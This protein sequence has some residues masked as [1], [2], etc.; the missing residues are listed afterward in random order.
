MEAGAELDSPGHSSDIVA[1]SCA[2]LRADLAELVERA[3]GL[4]ERLRCHARRLAATRG[5]PA[6]AAAAA[7]PPARL[8]AAE[9]DAIASRAAAAAARAGRDGAALRRLKRAR[10]EAAAR[11]RSVLGLAAAALAAVDWQAPSF[12]HAL[13]SHAG[14]LAGRITGTKND[15]QRDH[16][17]AADA[18][19]AAWL[20]AFVDAPPH[21]ALQAY[22]TAS[23]MAAFALA[24]S[25]VRGAA[26]E[27]PVLLGRSCWFQSR[28]LVRRLW[29]ER[30]V[31]DVDERDAEA[32]AAQARQA[33]A[34]AVF[35]DS[36]GNTG[37]L[38]LADLEGLLP[39]LAAQARRPLFV[40][41]DNTLLATA[42]QP[43][44]WLPP[45]PSRLR[46]LV[47]E[48]LNKYH[49]A[50]ADRCGAG[51]LWAAGTGL[52]GLF[53]TRMVLGANIP[54]T[55]V[56][57]LPPPRRAALDA[58]LARIGRNALHVAARV[59]AAID[60]GAGALPFAGVVHAALEPHPDALR[61]RAL[62]FAGGSFNLLPRDDY[63]GT[64]AALRFIDLAVHEARRAGVELVA[65]AGFGFDATRL[66]LTALFSAGQ[67][68]PFLRVAA[69]CECLADADRLA[70][71]LVR[72]MH[73]LAACAPASLLDDRA[74]ALR[75]QHESLRRHP[76]G[77]WRAVPA[78]PDSPSAA[79]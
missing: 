53:E 25:F 4:R 6:P 51:L 1:T 63:R 20:A 60:E 8:L 18:Y 33:G 49:Q 5:L 32:V 57:A 68:R 73:A 47:V 48:S 2:E 16:H 54:D 75:L 58:R 24:A 37:E 69:G 28:L 9:C 72:A 30:K 23:G 45:P 40:V 27:A 50:G 35:L 67:A 46:L 21:A 43:A 78:W 15:Y 36:L 41:V 59:Q 17:G 7:G 13:H 39:R 65:G 52:Q 76:S 19:E 3:R 38:P 71:V 56:H 61:A 62:A 29:P 55:H 44:R 70:A 12:A 42:C 22:A 14:L 34:A 31:I 64:D 66:Y 11:T 79:R 26:G 77:K 10:H 74:V